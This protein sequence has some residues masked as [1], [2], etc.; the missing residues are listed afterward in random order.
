MALNGLKEH[1]ESSIAQ[2]RREIQEYRAEGGR[3]AEV[4]KSVGIDVYQRNPQ[5][6]NQLVK[7]LVTAADALT[8][9]DFDNVSLEL[10]ALELKKNMRK[11]Q[12][13]ADDIRTRINLY[14]KKLEKFSE[15]KRN[16]EAANLYLTSK[17][18][19][20]LQELSKTAKSTLF[21]SKKKAQYLSSVEATKKRLSKL[22]Y[23]EDLSH[24]R[25]SEL[26]AKVNDMETRLKHLRLSLKSYEDLPP[27]LAGA[28]IKLEEKKAELNHL[29]T[30]LAETI[31][32]VAVASLHENQSA[33]S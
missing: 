23:N 12:R 2:M 8:V 16:I 30:Q 7:T 24:E 25:I 10:S 17:E 19:E 4:L 11:S 3:M 28:Q 22:G 27:S 18:D 32:D 31:G 15:Q 9:I 33:H 21:Y 13:E 26:G 5:I 29:E 6:D 1:R 20:F 14:K